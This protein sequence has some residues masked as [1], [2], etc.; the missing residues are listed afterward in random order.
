MPTGRTWA[1]TARRTSPT[2]RASGRSSTFAR[3]TWV[4]RS[5]T[6]PSAGWAS[7]SATTATSPK[8][9]VRWGST[10]RS[11]SSFLRRRA[12]ACR[13]TCGRSSRPATPSRTGTSWAPSTASARSRWA[14]TTTTG[15]ATSAIRVVSSWARLARTP[16]R[17]SSSATSTWTRSTRSGRRGS[18]TATGAPMRTRNWSSPDRRSEFLRDA[19]PAMKFGITLKP[20]HRFDRV[21][22]L[23]RRAEAS[24]F[25]HGWLF[26]SHI[27]WREPYPLLTL[28]ALN[29]ERM[30]L[31]ACVTN[32]ATRDVT[33]T[34]SALATLNEISGGR[35]D[36]GMGRGDSARRVMGKK[37]T[38]VAYMEEC[39]RIVRSLTAGEPVTLDG[40][41]IQ[42]TWATHGPVPVWVAGYGPMALAAAGRVADG[43]ILQLADPD[44]IRWCLG[45]MRDAETAAGRSP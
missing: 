24:G 18:S 4:T 16:A 15:P 33:V 22:D 25:D 41:E 19:P 39:C 17:S 44:I 9:P 12:A 28:M 37:P 29:T 6:P 43:V 13:C 26:D 40:T 38:T 36:L 32:P 11:W 3:A 2:S 31:G 5:S 14:T 35:M 23:V 45:F 34:A 7:T 21:V 20:E 1:S 42:L 8:A 10:A 30:R 27:L